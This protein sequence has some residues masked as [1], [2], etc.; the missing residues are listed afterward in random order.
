MALRLPEHSHCRYCG[1][2]IS[3]GEEYCN[4]QCKTSYYRRE[5]DDKRK[6]NMFYILAG[7]SVV[8]IVA[9]AWIF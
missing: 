7:L 6:D 8:V 3:F 5:A 9:L 4:E 1:D 2:P